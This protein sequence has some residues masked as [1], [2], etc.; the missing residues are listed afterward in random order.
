VIERD[1]VDLA[2]V[3]SQLQHTVHSGKVL[4]G[5][6]EL[7]SGALANFDRDSDNNLRFTGIG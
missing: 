3:F 5:T 6:I 2:E 4:D 1:L 7:T